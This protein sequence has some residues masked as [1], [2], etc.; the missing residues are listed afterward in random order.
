MKKILSTLLITAVMATSVTAC[1]QNGA[2]PGTGINKETG[3]TVLGGVG[4]AILGSQIGKGRGRWVGGAVGGL[5]GAALGNRIGASLDQA[6]MAAYDRTSQ[7]ALE[8]AKSGQTIA[9]SNPD[10]GNSGTIT[11]QKTYQASGGQYCREYQ[12]TVTVG[13]KKQS[14][15]GTACRQPDGSWQV[16]Q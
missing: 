3:G 6:D 16:T 11:P 5:L 2:A 12:Q 15:Y 8:S 9:W 4:G 7:S 1:Q 10:S 14:A 13:G